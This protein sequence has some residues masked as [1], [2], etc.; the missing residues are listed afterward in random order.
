MIEAIPGVLDK[1]RFWPRC[2]TWTRESW[3][4]LSPELSDRTFVKPF[5]SYS[6][7]TRQHGCVPLASEGSI[8]ILCYAAALPSAYKN[9]VR[10]FEDN[11]RCCTSD[12]W[13]RIS[14]GERMIP[15]FPVFSGVGYFLYWVWLSGRLKLG[16]PI[17]IYGALLLVDW[18]QQ[19]LSLTR[20]LLSIP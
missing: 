11:H 18:C 12:P 2:Q 16:P 3:D 1:K 19:H 13:T 4:A 8:I 15:F 6:M 7:L 9:R 17:S 20:M 10:L 14:V 5:A